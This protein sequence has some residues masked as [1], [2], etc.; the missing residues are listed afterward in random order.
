MANVSMPP[1]LDVEQSLHG[2]AELRVEPHGA[3]G[4]L[5][6]RLLFPFPLSL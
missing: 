6:G 3:L 4:E 5:T 2:P 1:T